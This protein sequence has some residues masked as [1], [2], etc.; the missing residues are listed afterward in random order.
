MRILSFLAVFGLLVVSPRATG[1]NQ[2]LTLSTLGNYPLGG[3]TSRYDYQSFDPTSHRLYI[4]HLGAGV[5]RV[6]DT[7]NHTVVGTVGGLPGV[8]GVLAVPELG[9]VYATATSAN[10]VA[11]VD[12]NTLAITALIPGGEFPDGLAYAPN[13]GKLYVSD[14]RAGNDIVIDTA[15]NAVV[16]T[17]PVGGE[18]GNTQ[19]DGASGQIFVAVHSGHL[20]AIDPTTDEVIGRYETLRCDTPHGLSI[21]A[22]RRLAFVACEGN[23]RLLVMDMDT[24]QATNTYQV[25]RGPDVLA[26]EPQQG[27]LYVAA[28]DGVLSVFRV[29]RFSRGRLD[30][31]NRPVA[32]PNAHSV[33]V[34]TTTGHVFLPTVDIQGVSVLREMVIESLGA[35]DD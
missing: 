27:I 18:A 35:N 25:G 30:I 26:F 5:M 23:D 10:A 31:I 7:E 15:A 19:F 14:L 12:P 29:D 3:D 32:G 9:T 11:A 1:A 13:V 28:E 6:F 8:H 21:D 33:S 17:I 34:D 2:S 4:A 22:T 16:A 20:V 24:M